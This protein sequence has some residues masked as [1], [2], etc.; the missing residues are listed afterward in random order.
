[1]STSKRFGLIGT[2]FLLTIAISFFNAFALMFVWNK[3]I[4]V[5]TGNVFPTIGYWAAFGFTVLIDLFTTKVDLK[6]EKGGIT[7]Y[8]ELFTLYASKVLIIGAIIGLAA[9]IGLGV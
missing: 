8:I 2:S 5:I 6:E 4:P 7:S 9:L 3:F 1:M